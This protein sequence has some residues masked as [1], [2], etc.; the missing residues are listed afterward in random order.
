MI[1]PQ[2]SHQPTGEQQK[3]FKCENGCLLSEE[4]L[5]VISRPPSK[6]IKCPYCGS[7]KIDLTT[8]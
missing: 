8:E 6:I 7:N 1:E 3:I 5:T 2:V 4:M